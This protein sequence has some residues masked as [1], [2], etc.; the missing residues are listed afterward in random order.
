MLRKIIARLS[1]I[2]LGQADAAGRQALDSEA[3]LVLTERQLR[4]CPPARSAAARLQPAL[5]VVAGREAI[6]DAALGKDATP[7]RV[8]KGTASPRVMAG[9]GRREA[10]LAPSRSQIH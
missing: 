7:T 8:G 9:N 5:R 10:P 1:R 4:D 6:S 2:L 3:R